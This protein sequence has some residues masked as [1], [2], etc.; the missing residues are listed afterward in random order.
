MSHLVVS[1]VG[2]VARDTSEVLGG[3]LRVARTLLD[4]LQDHHR[5]VPLPRLDGCLN[6]LEG[7]SEIR[8]EEN[9]SCIIWRNLCCL[10][11]GDLAVNR[12]TKP[13]SQPKA[14]NPPKNYFQ[15]FIFFLARIFFLVRNIYSLPTSS[16]LFVLTEPKK[17]LS[18]Q[19]KATIL[20][21]V[22][23]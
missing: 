10:C 17:S 12:L 9:L 1:C 11:W 18:V 19:C 13:I 8:H 20:R 15:R 5:L 21:H 23:L 16:T 3:G 4:V 6:C 22:L 2:V 14:E 7:R